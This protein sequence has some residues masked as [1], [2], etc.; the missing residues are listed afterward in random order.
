MLSLSP[1]YDLFRFSFPKD[2]I[3]KDI[4]KKYNE[5]LTRNAGVI[6]TPIDYLNESIKGISI[7]GISD[8]LILQQQHSYN[9]GIKGLGKI[10]VEPKREQIYQSTSNPLDKINPD[11]KV[12]FRMN[13]GLYNYFMLYEIVFYQICKPINNGH[14]PVLYVDL[15]NEDGISTARIKFFN[16]LIDGIDGLDFSYDK[17]ERDSGTFDLSLKFSNIDFEFLYEDSL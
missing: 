15:L 5:L 14:I 11:I 12:T 10:N 4:E 6:T 3:P 16:V 8:I 13:Q 9:D 1:R 2:F 17:V 7:P